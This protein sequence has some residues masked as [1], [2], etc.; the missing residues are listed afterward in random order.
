MKQNVLE[1]SMYNYGYY[2]LLDMYLI[3]IIKGEKQY[4]KVWQKS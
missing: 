2:Y 3:E 4:E 1:F